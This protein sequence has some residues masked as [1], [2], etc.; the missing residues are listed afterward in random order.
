MSRRRRV[1]K[2]TRLPSVSR[3]AFIRN[4]GNAFVV[5]GFFV[6]VVGVAA[7]SWFIFIKAQEE[8]SVSVPPLPSVNQE[9]LNALVDELDR[10][11]QEYQKTPQI[12]LR[13]PF[14]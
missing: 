10:R 12:P 6:V 2:N 3:A 9:D 14:R 1:L 13:N 11:E 8:P 7:V 5:L 4:I